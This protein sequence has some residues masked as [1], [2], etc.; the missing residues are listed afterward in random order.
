MAQDPQPAASGER[1]QELR[2][3]VDR[4]KYV[5]F[6]RYTTMQTLPQLRCGRPRAGHRP[7]TTTRS[8]AVLAA[9]FIAGGMAG[10]FIGTFAARRLTAKEALSRVFAL[11]ILAIAVYMMWKSA[12][13]LGVHP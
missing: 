2:C 13:A 10:G 7:G 1:F 11:L 9:L 3:L 12:M 5:I 8:G 6:H 4:G